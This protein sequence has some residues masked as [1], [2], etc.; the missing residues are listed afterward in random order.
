MSQVE[1]GDLMVI[2]RGQ[3]ATARRSIDGASQAGWRDGPW[4]RASDVPRDMGIVRGL[5]EGTKLCRVSAESYSLEY[6]ASRGGIEEARRLAHEPASESNPVRTSDIFLAV[7]AISPDPEDEE[8]LF[9]GS[10]SNKAEEEESAATAH[11]QEDPMVSFAVYLL[12][13]VH[14]ITFG[15]V[16][17]SLPAK[18]IRWLD[19]TT[20]LT[21]L[22][23]EEG[24]SDQVERSGVPA[25]ILDIIESGGVDPREWVSEWVEEAIDLS[26][27]VIAQRYVARRMGVGEGGIGKGKQRA[28]VVMGEG[29][30]EAARAGL[31]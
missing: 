5:P 15:T 21:P 2:Q 14:E 4:W 3:E 23:G 12:D 24:A 11:D 29:G 18:W 27:G 7:Q 28:E 22:S 16:S 6:Y 30:G 17:Q 19:T 20:P 9:E 8:E 1:G 13:P 10:A 31:I 25:E 26:I